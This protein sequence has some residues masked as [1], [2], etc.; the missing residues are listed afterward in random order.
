MK[1]T[2]KTKLSLFTGMMILL[3]IL[4]ISYSLF[5]YERKVR[6]EDIKNQQKAIFANFANL[7][8]EALLVQDEILLLNNMRA[9]KKTYWGIVYI[10]FITSEGRIIYTDKDKSNRGIGKQYI[11]S[12]LVEQYNTGYD[13]DF[14]EISAP[15]YIS[16]KRLGVGQIGFSQ[17]DYN[18]YIDEIL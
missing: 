4:F 2:I 18:K 16:G 14:L 11:G 13:R 7:S 10:N 9:L 6:T 3:V 8:K 15:V 17:T 5:V 12:R 1:L